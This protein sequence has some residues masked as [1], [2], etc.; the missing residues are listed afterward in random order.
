MI[1]SWIRVHFGK[2]PINGGK[3]PSD[4]SVVN[5]KNFL[6]VLLFTNIVWFKKEMNGIALHGLPVKQHIIL[7]FW[8][9]TVCKD[10]KCLKHWLHECILG[11]RACRLV[12][13]CRI[14]ACTL[15]RKTVHQIF[16]NTISDS[17]GAPNI[18]ETT[19]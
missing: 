5:N 13:R 6:A 16:C 8:H 7:R 18:W 17:Q 1:S 3:P 14:P 9:V 2:Y 19:P 11:L 12:N 10:L 15:R 4:K